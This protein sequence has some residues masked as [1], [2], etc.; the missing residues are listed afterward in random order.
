MNNTGNMQI[1]GTDYQG[2]R[3]SKHFHC[4]NSFKFYYSNAQNKR[5]MPHE[6]P[7]LLAHSTFHDRFIG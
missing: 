5:M 3:L 2:K 6:V 4:F 7:P 1:I